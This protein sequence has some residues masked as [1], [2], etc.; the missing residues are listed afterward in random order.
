MK[1]IIL[2]AL[3][4]TS[5]VFSQTTDTTHIY[6]DSLKTTTITIYKNW[7]Y[8]PG[9]DSAWASTKFSS[10][11][12]KTVDC[13]LFLDSAETQNWN[14]I[15]WFRKTMVIDSALINKSIALILNHFGASELYINGKLINKF[16]TVSPRDKDEE[17]YYSNSEPIVINFDTSRTYLLSV[18]YSNHPAAYNPYLFQRLSSSAGFN[19]TLKSLSKANE[20]Y[21]ARVNKVGKN[22]ILCGIF[23][24]IFVIY[25]LLFFFY[26]SKREYLYYALFTF[27]F[28]YVF[29][30]T[31]LWITLHSGIIYLYV[32]SI[33]AP[34]FQLTIF[35]SVLAFLYQI[36]YGRLLKIFRYI[37]LLGITTYVLQFF[38]SIAASTLYMFLAV[39]VF[40]SFE[41][42]RVTFLAIKRKQKNAGVIGAGLFGFA[43]LI[44]LIFILNFFN[45]RFDLVSSIGIALLFSIPLSMSI[46][47]ARTS[48][49]TNENLEIQLANVKKLSDEAIEQERKSAKIAA[50]N[51]RKTQELE[52]ARKLQLS[53]LPE[54]VPQLSNFDIAV[55]MQTATE[56][57]GDYYDFSTGND[58]SINICVGD[59]TGHGMKAGTL[60]TMLKALFIA[61]SPKETIE[62]FFA[63]T[64]SAIKNSHLVRMM[65]GFSML[66]IS[67]NKA[68]HINAGLPSIYHF[69]KE[70]G[71]VEEIKQHNMPLG[72]MK[73]VEYK[74]TE[75][76]LNKG[77]VI[78]M[79]SDG[80]PELHNPA[81][82]QFGYE[83]VLSSF[84]ETARKEPEE[85]IKHLNEEADRWRA[86]KDLLDDITFVVVKVK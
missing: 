2:L 14:G 81:D 28:S 83:R 71:K 44:I 1:N 47:L 58:G 11:G 24:S 19:L 46:Y 79:M 49:Q 16:G 29:L 52:E 77:D 8:H 4:F 45:I 26:S 64:N 41:I 17:G 23:V 80:F 7:D 10:A 48:S 86:D 3:M 59:A 85:I 82:E 31:V 12:W 43:G 84:E 61:M 56:V 72:A 66:N 27:S 34:L 25:V 55:Y 30:R 78:L 33:I 65:V 73:A 60:V 13:R 15:G 76:T 39:V 18:R 20:Y 42:L 21:V 69:N 40:T 51:E 32:D 57:G 22:A 38:Q 9:D 63:S 75:I 67:G 37:L 54:S 50:E 68:K 6:G 35:V 53:M 70:E 5:V 74:A 36:F 62:E